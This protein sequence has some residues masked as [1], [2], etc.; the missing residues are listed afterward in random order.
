MKIPIGENEMGANMINVARE[1]LLS[2]DCIQAQ[3]CHT[4]RCPSGIAT[5][6]KHLQNG[7]NSDLKSERCANYIKGLRK[8]INELTTACGYAHVSEI[9]PVNV[10]IQTGGD[11]CFL[12]LTEY[13]AK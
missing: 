11:K 9:K 13:F 6:N 7:I 8:E 5:Q 2:I 3:S 1:A 12:N 4:N 10:L